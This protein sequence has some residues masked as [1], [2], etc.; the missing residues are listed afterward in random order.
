MIRIYAFCGMGKTTLCDKYGYVDDDMYYPQRPV[1]KQEDVVLTN[2]PSDECNAYFLPP[3]Y[4]VAFHRLALEKQKFFN[5][6]DDLLK[7]EYETVKK[8]YN[9]VIKDYITQEDVVNVLKKEV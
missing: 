8:K 1:I 9:P 6:Y 7:K 4:N 2:E 3:S 5:E